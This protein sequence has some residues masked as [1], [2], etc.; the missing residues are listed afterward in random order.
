MK[1]GTYPAVVSVDVLL[2]LREG[3]VASVTELRNGLE[4]LVNL[5]GRNREGEVMGQSNSMIN[6]KPKCAQQ[7]R[8]EG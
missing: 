7:K 3:N 5:L 4:D 8:V 1:T 6:H 2:S